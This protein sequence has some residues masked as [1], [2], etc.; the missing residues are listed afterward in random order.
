MAR[1]GIYVGGKEIIRR[2]VGDKIVWRKAYYTQVYSGLYGVEINERQGLEKEF[3]IYGDGFHGLVG[4][5]GEG[6][7]ELNG[8]IALFNSLDCEHVS[9]GY[10]DVEHQKAIITFLNQNDKNLF[11]NG[12]IYSA[13]IKIFKKAYK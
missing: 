5:L 6:G 7:I 10:R 12:H 4:H 13:N 2:Y 11:L 1:V 8:K 3:K 9:G